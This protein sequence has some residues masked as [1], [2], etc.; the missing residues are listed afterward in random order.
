MIKDIVLFKPYQDNKI[1]ENA[2]EEKDYS[3]DAYRN[4]VHSVL[5]ANRVHYEGLG[6]AANQLAMDERAFNIEGVTF[7]NPRV[8]NGYGDEKPFSEGCISFLNVR[9]SVKR[10][11]HVE[12]EYTDLDGELIKKELFGLEAVAFQHELDHLNGITMVDNI[13]SNVQKRKF[14]EKYKKQFKKV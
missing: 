8:I 9:A 4:G 2:I 13:S 6:I 14:L 10:Q 11:Q 5:E 1:L 12:V 7:F 3:D